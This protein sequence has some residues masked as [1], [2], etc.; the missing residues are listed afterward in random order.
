MRKKLST[1]VIIYY[2]YAILF[3]NNQNTDVTKYFFHICGQGKEFKG[4]DFIC[5]LLSSQE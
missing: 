1:F 4:N 2:G 3:P 5:L